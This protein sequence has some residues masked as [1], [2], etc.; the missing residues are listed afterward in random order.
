MQEINAISSDSHLSGIRFKMDIKQENYNQSNSVGIVDTQYLNIEDKI[1]LENGIDFG[2]LTIAYETYGELNKTKDNALLVLHALSGDAHAAGYN[3]PE[4]KKPGWWDDLIGPGKAFDTNKYFVIS[5]NFLG[6]CKGTTGPS[7]IN[8]ETG[9]P[10]GTSF[11]VI[12]IEDMVKLQKKLL[13]FLGIEKFIVAG[14]SMGGMQAIEWTINYPEMIKSTIIIAST[15][16]LS[17]QGIAFNE[18]GRNAI[19]YDPNWNNGN[20]Y[21]TQTPPSSGLSIAR[22]IGHITY[23][24]EESMHEKFGRRLQ[25]KKDLDFNFDV[26]FQVESYLRY[27]GKSF[28][29]RFDANSYLY[30]TKAMD[31]FDIP[32]KYGSL[33]KAFKNAKSKFLVISFNSDWL[34]P[35]SQSKEI[36]KALMKIDKE[37][38]YCELDT[39]Y[40][41]DAFL[42]EYE[43]QTKIIKSFLKEDK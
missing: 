5:S 19:I 24:S 36:V 3:S 40:G 26:N 25:D 21:E 23:L 18:V 34:F 2:P 13:D 28:V 22:M 27:Q 8:P 12:T 20:Y 7:S 31:Y 39:P 4:E 16:R 6:G 32:Q 15:S 29:D 11:P 9:K 30:I 37:V 1:K 17:A 35:S 38:T 33:M 42:L 10:Y 43:Q 14:G 41:H